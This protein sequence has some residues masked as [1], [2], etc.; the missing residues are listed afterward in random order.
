MSD[1]TMTMT[2]DEALALLDYLEVRCL[3]SAEGPT[4]KVVASFA[5]KSL[6]MVINRAYPDDT[7]KDAQ[8][9]EPDPAQP[10]LPHRIHP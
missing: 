7:A 3:K 4:D 8:A 2:R 1:M 6:R 10:N 5:A 9:P